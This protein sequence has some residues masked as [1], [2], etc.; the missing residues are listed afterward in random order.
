[1]E[2]V[3]GGSGHPPAGAGHPRCPRQGPP[4]ADAVAGR[5]PPAPDIPAGSGADYHG[6]VGVAMNPLQ[7]QAHLSRREYLTTTASGL[8]MMALGSMLTADGIL[9]PSTARAASP[10]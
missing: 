8:G 6:V 3:V 7:E 2:P 9:T 4:G 5:T 10:A 1:M